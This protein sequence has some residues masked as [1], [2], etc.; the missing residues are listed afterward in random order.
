MSKDVAE[1]GELLKLRT[2]LLLL[3]WC[4]II[5]SL[6]GFLIHNLPTIY[7]IFQFYTLSLPCHS[8]SFLHLGSLGLTIPQVFLSLDPWQPFLLGYPR[9]HPSRISW[10]ST[11]PY[12]DFPIL[13]WL[14]SYCT[15]LGSPRSSWPTTPKT[16]THSRLLGIDSFASWPHYSD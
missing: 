10:A 9:P 5:L 3:C 1:E 8:S 15:H 12:V 6:L 11:N 4:L 13:A 16:P 7:V 2:M 14:S